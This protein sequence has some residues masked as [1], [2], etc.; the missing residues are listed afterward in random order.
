M[1][2]SDVTVLACKLKRFL[3]EFICIQVCVR[4]SLREGFLIEELLIF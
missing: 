3:V 1:Q 4:V 2:E